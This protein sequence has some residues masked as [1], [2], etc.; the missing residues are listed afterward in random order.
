[1]HIYVYVY[2]IS[3]DILNTPREKVCI[4]KYEVVTS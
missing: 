4:D 1:M 2:P 3:T